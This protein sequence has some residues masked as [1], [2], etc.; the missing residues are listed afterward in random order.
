MRSPSCRLASFSLRACFV[1]VCLHFRRRRCSLCLHCP[2]L[3]QFK[4][5]DPT[6]NMQKGPPCVGVGVCVYQG[7]V[8]RAVGCLAAPVHRRV[9]VQSATRQPTSLAPFALR[10]LIF[11][12]GCRIRIFCRRRNFDEGGFPC[13]GLERA[14]ILRS[15]VRR[16]RGS[17]YG[18]FV[19]D[20]GNVIPGDRCSRLRN[21]GGRRARDMDSK[22]QPLKEHGSGQHNRIVEGEGRGVGSR[23]P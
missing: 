4:V 12:D 15:G 18:G 13:R 17:A 23:R 20:R 11:V 21:F 3:F 8:E 9:G 16:V 22:A 10:G 7:L 6:R 19:E 14:S 1:Y 5:L 2:R